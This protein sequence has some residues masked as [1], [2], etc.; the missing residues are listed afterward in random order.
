MTTA[1][2]DRAARDERWLG[3]GYLGERSN[4][5]GEVDLVAAT[6]QRI[7]DIANERG[8]DYEALF[9]WANSKNGRHFGDVVFGGTAR[10]DERI[11]E[12]LRFELI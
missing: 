9:D 7:V 11:S 5:Q 4:H 10:F 6:D 8:W 2:L 12:A 1:D 3:F